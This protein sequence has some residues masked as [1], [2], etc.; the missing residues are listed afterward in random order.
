M[1]VRSLMRFAAPAVAIL[2]VVGCGRKSFSGSGLGNEG[3]VKA[4]N[5]VGG[6]AVA[7]GDFKHVVGLAKDGRIFC[8]GN[9]VESNKILT[10]GHCVTNFDIDTEAALQA[11]FDKTMDEVEKNLAGQ[12]IGLFNNA[13]LAAKRTLFKAALRRVI[14]DEGKSIKIYVGS[15]SV[16]GSETGLDV[17]ADVALSPGGYAYM[18]ASVLKYTNLAL[19]EDQAV[20][21]SASFDYAYMTLKTT[22]SGVTPVPVINAQE[23]SDNV[24]LGQDVRVVGFGLKVD[25]RF[26]RASRLII[27]EL[28]EK[29]AAEQDEQKKQELQAQLAEEKMMGQAFLALYFNSGNKNMVDLKLENYDHTEIT[30]TKKG[31]DLAG[32]CNGD[33]GGPALVKLRNGEWRQLGVVVTVDYCGNKTHVSPR[34]R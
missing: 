13:P 5:I 23:H 9:L 2:L 15:S 34:F 27:K 12:D 8:S 33:S 26:L 7:T 22:L 14:T 16:G 30:L 4:G 18:E 11:I 32:A 24:L 31:S 1:K 6:S 21:Y 17:V 19:P 20:K 3:Q 25:G 28:E 10:A 29:I